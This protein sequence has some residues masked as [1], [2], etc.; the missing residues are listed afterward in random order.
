MLHRKVTVMWH[1]IL[2]YNEDGWRATRV[3]LDG[4]RSL[5]I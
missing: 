2:D 3:V 1:R 4:L 5:A